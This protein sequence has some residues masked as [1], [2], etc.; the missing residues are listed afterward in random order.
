[1]HMNF[2]ELVAA[3][4]SRSISVHFE[5]AQL[6]S[7]NAKNRSSEDC[8]WQDPFMRYDL[9]FYDRAP[10]ENIHVPGPYWEHWEQQHRKSHKCREIRP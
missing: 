9:R 3:A 5:T 4:R 6:T 10:P 7:R 8:R 1:V 2:A